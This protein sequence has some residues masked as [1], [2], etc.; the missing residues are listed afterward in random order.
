MSKETTNTVRQILMNELGLTR[1]SIREEMEKIV[2]QTVERALK[3]PQIEDRIRSV[4]EAKIQTSLNPYRY[5]TGDL[6]KLV[7]D[8]VLKQAKRE[9]SALIGNRLVIN[10]ELTDASEAAK[11][12]SASIA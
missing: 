7:K 8:E 9:V 3:T 4:I 11:E 10:L 1:E 5:G 6:E 12:T 2:V